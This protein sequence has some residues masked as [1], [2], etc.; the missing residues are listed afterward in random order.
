VVEAATRGQH[1][2]TRTTPLDVR[3]ALLDNNSWVGWDGPD[4]AEAVA[5]GEGRVEGHPIALLLSDFEFKAGSVGELAANRLVTAIRRATDEGL[6]LLASTASG[7]TR[8]Q[9]GTSAF[10]RMLDV[11]HALIAHRAASLPYLVHL[12][13]PT[14]GGV[15]AS[16]GSLG[17]VTY[18]EPR[19]LIGLLGPKVVE[20]LEGR[21]LP[22][23]VQT[24]ENLRNHGVLDGVV[25]L[26]ELRE[27]TSKVLGLTNERVRPR[28]PLAATP[29]APR[30]EPVDPWAA[31]VATRSPG[32]ISTTDLLAQCTDAVHL[33]GRGV[34]ALGLELALARVDGAACVFI[35]QDRAAQLAG[36]RLG[37]A[38]MQV[39]RRG[40]HLAESL[41]LPLVTVVDTPGAALTAEAESGGLAR[42]IAQTIATMGTLTVPS[43][44]VLLG[45]GTGAAALAIL[46]A[47][48]TVATDHSW[49]TPLPIEG[50]SV[51]VH[52]DTAHAC[53]L[54]RH[55]GIGTQDLQRLGRVHAVVP[56][57]RGETVQELAQAVLT[58]TRRQ[59][60]ALIEG[61]LD[62]N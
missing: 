1:G 14:T 5:T 12:R 17:Q 9:E 31:I 13:H 18:A 42:E 32:W 24:A 36:A 4:S 21:R 30:D 60:D 7:G 45:Q 33:D 55:Q 46:P 44:S 51:I 6:P 38:A 39:A 58:E 15:F 56:S 20:Q 47:Q 19:A 28:A 54:A 50:A 16:W 41:R 40:M 26:A 27:R 43:V 49:L 8:L 53:E 61:S 34:E 2:L 57:G 52:G 22:A 25:T 11:T 35:A 10:L 23:E 37:P 3:A 59:I 62:E 29:A 48:R